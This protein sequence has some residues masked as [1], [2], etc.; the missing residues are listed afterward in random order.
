MKDSD[1][2]RQSDLEANI[3]ETFDLIK[4]YEDKRRL[5]DD[6]K[7]IM[8][9][10]RHIADL[11]KLLEGHKV[12]LS[13]LRIASEP[14]I[15]LA[16]L[17]F[18]SPVLFGR[19]Q[20][21]KSLDAAWTDPNTNIVSLVA[22]GGVGKTSLVNKWLRDMKDD[23]FRGA[24]RAFGW[25]FY[26]QGA[27]E[28]KQVSADEF[29]ASALKWFGDPEPDE[30][31]PWE[32]GERLADFIKKQ[33]TLLILDG[34]EPLQN[35]PGEGGGRVKDP[36]LQYLLRELAYNNSGLC[37]ITTRMEVADIK[38]F[39]GNSTQSIPL[40]SLSPDAGIELLKHLGV[41]GTSEELRQ[42][43][44]EFGHHALALTLL[45]NYLTTV[46]D[47][48]VQKRD[49]IATLTD[50]VENGGHAKRVMESYEKWLKNKPELNMLYIMGVFGRP[51]EGG[52]IKAF[53]AKPVINGLTSDFKK[54]SF[55]NLQDALNHLSKLG[56]LS[57]EDGKADKLDC[58]PLMREYFG[59]KLKKNNPEA[60]KEAH[61]RLYNHYKNTAKEF[62]DTIK[63]MAPLYQ[64]VAHGCEAGL[65]QEAL[66]EVYLRR[67][68]RENY[69]FSWTNLGTVGADL[70]AL[71]GFFDVP[72]N[73][74][75]PEIT[76]TDKSFVL[77][78]AGLYLRT[79]G[80]LV[81]ASQPMQ[82]ALDAAIL[83]KNWINAANTAS[84]LSELYL[85]L[86]NMTSAL[87]YAQQSVDFAN[88]S[89]YT[90]MQI[91]SQT[92]LFDVQYQMGQLTARETE[93]AFAEA[94]EMQ[95]K[96]QPDYPYLHSLKGFRYCDL[97]LSQ[98]EY[99]KVLGRAGQTLEWVTAIHRLFDIA[100][101]NLSLGRAHLHK[102]QQ[103]GSHD[104]TQ[105]ET[106]LS[107]AVKGLRGAE[108]Q[109]Y[110]PRALLAY[111]EL[112]RVQDAFEKAQHDL[113]EAMTIAK[114][115]GMNLYIADCH[116]E[117][118]RL[119]LAMRDKG[120]ARE[121]LDIAKEMIENMG[122]HRR[123]KDVKEIEEKL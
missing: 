85:S 50:D 81:E 90:V 68:L 113:T 106:Y 9:C 67:I 102:T 30:G 101:D 35:P 4:G 77:H 75:V 114:R 60:W 82:A 31:S 122:Y 28:D 10:E 117:Y 64:S 15:F 17:P 40:D 6:P 57:N 46:Y 5:S 63:D 52:A 70:A 14:K 76:D 34:V 7:E 107:Q 12:E 103:E 2:K 108:T 105:A 38:D 110:L 22:W 79:L 78:Q 109:H 87:D 119:Y 98:G 96:S 71:S 56:L 66:I 33:K 69:H 92:T 123:D 18:A 84:L 86:G 37:V 24:E 74:L 54:L 62:P 93:A 1:Q 25:S 11:R 47:G 97:L 53:M 29:I 83:Q 115:G 104:Y 59:E 100:L 55:K 58:H 44:S 111:A 23:N 39:I 20:E 65:Y 21:L 36:G 42:A 49:E 80:R 13:E 8:N 72:W 45:G 3:S 99:E 41:K 121:N 94:E 89:D 112:Y 43:S 61:S 16:K 32:K 118:A 88:R 95:K 116:L 19:E 27:S 51:A 48:D 73:Q 120:K 26:S 91:T